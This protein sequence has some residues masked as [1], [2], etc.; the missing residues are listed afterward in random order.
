MKLFQHLI[1]VLLLFAGPSTFAQLTQPDSVPP[2]AAPRIV[3]LPRQMD[4]GKIPYG[5]PVTR[6]FVVQNHSDSVL[7]LTKVRTGCHCTTATW[8]TDSIPPG[9]SGVLHVTFDA[10]KEDAFYK[11]IIVF[12]NQ[13]VE[14][15][16]GLILKGIVDKKPRAKEDK[17]DPAATDTGN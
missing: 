5:I 3:W 4:I 14:Q 16:V 6:D 17:T 8:T 7:V 13:D 10:A 11:V 12:T 2:I 9:K 1:V 15:P